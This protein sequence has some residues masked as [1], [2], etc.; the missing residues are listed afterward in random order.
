M[1]RKILFQVTAPAIVTGVL[2]VGTC[3]VSAWSIHRL[4]TN[5][6]TI[7]SENVISLHAALDLEN[8]MRQLRY[9]SLRYLTK[10]TAAGR[11]QILEDEQ[12]FE[13]DLR[14]VSI[15][16]NSDAERAYLRQ[17]ED[18]YR[19][20]HDEMAALR[21]EV[22]RHGPRQDFASLA[23]THPIRHIV[24]PCQ[25][26]GRVAREQ[27]ERTAEDSNLLSGKAWRALLLL[28]IAGPLGGLVAGYGIVRGLTRSIT[29]LSVRV[30]DVVKRLD[31]PL[32]SEKESGVRSQ[33]SGVGAVDEGLSGEEKTI[34]IGEVTVASDGDLGAMDRQLQQVLEKVEQVTQ[35]LQRQHRDILRAERLAALGQLAAGVAHEI[36]N[37]LTGIKLL[38]EA[39]CRPLCRKSLTEEDLTVILG[40]ISRLEEIVQNFLTFARPPALD[41]K[42]CDL[43]QQVARP[44]DLVRARA[45]QQGVTIQLAMPEQP[46]MLSL[47]PGHFNTVIVN[48]LINALDAMPQGGTITVEVDETVLEDS[49]DTNPKRQRGTPAPCCR[50][51]V[52]DT[53]SGI[54]P[55]I[56]ERLFTPF[57]STKPTGTGLGLSLS[58]R[59]VQEHGGR[60]EAMNRPEGGACFTIEIPYR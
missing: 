59:I 39:A 40:E 32:S 50:V 45:R 1:N 8:Q 48:L 5:L 60:I 34:A 47:D 25:E 41:R 9:H 33:E 18:G 2:L 13:R 17:I 24:K 31:D 23:D 16:A 54:A 37:P 19:K 12:L 52:C 20:Y 27:L 7:L 11:A 55:Q 30:S 51:R 10:P 15:A 38:V 49:T 28:G 58:R 6:G 46:V 35:R 57:A 44:V 43:R 53:G 22:D 21:A 36:R 42:R 26:L 14:Q 4:Q 56:A 29:Q 3:L